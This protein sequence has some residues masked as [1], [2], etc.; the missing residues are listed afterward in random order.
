MSRG[1][2][3]RPLPKRPGPQRFAGRLAKAGEGLTFDGGFFCPWGACD[4][5]MQV[6][7]D[8]D[9]GGSSYKAMFEGDEIRLRYD[10]ALESEWG[11]AGY[12]GLTGRE[13]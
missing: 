11:G 9:G 10:E 3:R 1:D 6:Q 5:P 8:P 7:F 13:Q 2:G 4:E 12:G